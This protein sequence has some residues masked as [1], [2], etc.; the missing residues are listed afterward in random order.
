MGPKR[1]IGTEVSFK[2]P[3]VTKCASGSRE[4][5]A[6][7][8]TAPFYALVLPAYLRAWGPILEKNCCHSRAFHIVCVR[9]FLI[10]DR[11]HLCLLQE[12]RVIE[13]ES[14]IT[15]RLTR[16]PSRR[17]LN[18]QLTRGWWN[19]KASRWWSSTWI[20]PYNVD[21]NI[22]AAMTP[23]QAMSLRMICIQER[24]SLQKLDS[25]KQSSYS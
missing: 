25:R 4:A 12:C 22:G 5:T 17:Q 3:C 24:T 2:T 10:R 7:M 21:S 11:T 19:S 9:A 20:N 8:N 15:S 14:S 16:P 6:A 18:N 13:G 23:K 1:P